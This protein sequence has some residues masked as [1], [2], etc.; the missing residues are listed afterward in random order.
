MLVDKELHEAGLVADNAAQFVDLL[1]SERG[2]AYTYGQFNSTNWKTR[3][4]YT[5]QNA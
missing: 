5:A 3:S 2:R 1:E 4:D